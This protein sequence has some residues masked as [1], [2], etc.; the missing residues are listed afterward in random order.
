MTTVYLLRH[1]EDVNP[2][3]LIKGHLPGF[4]LSKEG[5]KQIEG[6]AKLLE[7]EG[8]SAIYTSPLLRTRQS[9]EI[10]QKAFPK[11]SFKVLEELTE[12]GTKMQGTLYRAMEG[13]PYLFFRKHYEPEEKVIER[14]RKGLEIIVK[15][16]PDASVVAF[17]HGWPI[18]ALRMSLEGEEFSYPLKSLPYNKILVLR[19]D[20]KLNLLEPPQILDFA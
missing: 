3:G 2:D 1:G 7:K 11:A 16:N 14:M 9:A 12:W 10:F 8:I 19:L 5:K 20:V 13:K 17:S 4:P 15:E 6:A 18:T